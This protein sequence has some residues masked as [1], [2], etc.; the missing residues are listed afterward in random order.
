MQSEMASAIATLTQRNRHAIGTII[1]SVNGSVA[2]QLH[3]LAMQWWKT[4]IKEFCSVVVGL[5]DRGD[6][7]GLALI[8]HQPTS[9]L[10]FILAVVQTTRCVFLGQHPYE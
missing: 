3:H 8:S 10:Q 9:H 1:T 5:L 6:D 7:S 4:P 2:K